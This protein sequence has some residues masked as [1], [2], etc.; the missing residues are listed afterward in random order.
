MADTVLVSGER[1]D[2]RQ[3]VLIVDDCHNAARM[4]QVLLK[5][6]GYEVSTAH[7]GLE[8]LAVAREQRPALFLMDLTLP[9]MSGAEVAEELCNLDCFAETVIVR[10]SGYGA[11]RL[12][13]PTP[14]NGHLTKP[15]DLD[16]PLRFSP[17]NPGSYAALAIR[18]TTKKS[19]DPFEI[20]V[21]TLKTL[22]M[23]IFEP[24]K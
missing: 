11:D 23:E 19:P 9:R 1:C 13:Q 15:V 2:P 12:P 7:E 24:R 10:I 20:G 18:F 3:R 16:S 5:M 17:N 8:A 14:F 6:Q 22:L 4:L 21:R